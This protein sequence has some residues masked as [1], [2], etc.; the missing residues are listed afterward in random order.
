MTEGFSFIGMGYG[1]NT[2]E[3]EGLDTVEK[4]LSRLD[5]NNN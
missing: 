3:K 1:D 2:Q 5:V 4:Y